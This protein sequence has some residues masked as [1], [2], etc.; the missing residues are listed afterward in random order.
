MTVMGRAKV[1]VDKAATLGH[2]GGI[3]VLFCNLACDVGSLRETGPVE[4][5]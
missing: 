4:V 5:Y 3:G 2:D 1:G